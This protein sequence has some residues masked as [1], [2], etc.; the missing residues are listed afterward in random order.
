MIIPSQYNGFDHQ[1]RRTFNVDAGIGEAMLISAALGG[2]TAAA[3]GQDPLKGALLGAALGGVGGSMFGGAAGAGTG[4]ATGAGA[5]GTTAAELAAAEAATGAATGA[6]A[7]IGAGA[8]NAVAPW[9]TDI[10]GFNT[11]ASEAG[12]APSMFNTALD[13]AKQHPY[14]T[15]G[16]GL[17]AASALAPKYRPP[18]A[19]KY[20][21]PLSKF[22]YDPFNYTPYTPVPPNP[23]YRA[24]YAGGGITALAQGGGLNVPTGPVE[25]MSQQVVGAGGMYP[26]S[27][28]DRTYFATPTQMPTSAEVVNADYEPATNPYTGV[29][30]AKGGQAMLG[31]IDDLIETAKTTRGGMANLYGKARSDD[32]DALA[33]ISK[34][35]QQRASRRNMMA[36]GGIAALKE[37]SFVVPADVVSHIGNGSTDAGI[38]AL[39]KKLGAKPIRGGGDG[40]SDSIPTSIEGKQKARVADGEAVVEPE[41]VKRIGKG[42]SKE[43]AKKLY[44][45]MDKVRKART[46]TV[47]QGKQINPS[48]Y[49]PA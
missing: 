14:M 1:G 29:M 36:E 18:E 25:R 23:P 26:Q 37:G 20:D 3:T 39:N 4:A 31:N 2:G 21:G 8:T 28:M 40:M 6:T 49:V 35:Q 33:A 24:Q 27:Q 10:T 11:L 45:M 5:A 47:K 22:R 7:G 13:F 42:S 30:M 48:K 38:T 9:A 12:Q 34:M 41:M 32:A 19:E 15:A 44:D 43:G 16:L 46:G 17:T